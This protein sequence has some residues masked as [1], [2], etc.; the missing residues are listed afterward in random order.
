MDEKITKA[1]DDAAKNRFVVKGPYEELQRKT[2]NILVEVETLTKEHVL[3][4]NRLKEQAK[5]LQD[6]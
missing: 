2:Q 3:Y 5:L 1:F 4:I 6:N